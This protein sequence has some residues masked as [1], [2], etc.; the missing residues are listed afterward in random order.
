MDNKILHIAPIEKFIPSF[1]NLIKNHFPSEQHTIFTVGNYDKYPYTQAEN[2]I[3][4]EKFNSYKTLYHLLRALHSHKKIILH[5]LFTHQLTMLLC[6]MPWL[7]KKCQWVIWGS[8]LYYHQLAVKNTRYRLIEMLRKVLIS[9]LSGFITYVDGDYHKAQQW[10]GAKG[11]LYEC[12]V[13][14]SNVYVGNELSGAELL[15]SSLAHAKLNLLVGNSSDPT[16]NHQ[17]IFKRLLEL[18]VDKLVGKIYCPLS[19]GNHE[20]AREIKKLGEALFGDK[21]H[22]LMGFIPLIE[23]NKILDEI[24]IAIFAHNRQ[25]AMGNIINLL[26]RGKTVYMRSDTSSYF[27][28][29]KLGIQVFSIEH[30]AL[31]VQSSNVS[32]RNNENV[33][34]YFSE[35]NLV[36]QWLKIFT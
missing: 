7:H 2:T 29:A 19:Y 36:K 1:I 12:I 4:F 3:H 23:Y 5:G 22:P 35:E 32:I 33:R 16:N 14:K 18:D 27:L 11:R 26:G 10:Y 24:D 6:F 15:N 30:L 28:F 31:N 20:Y 8:D 9:R 34:D 17:D 25:Q 21:F 13:Y